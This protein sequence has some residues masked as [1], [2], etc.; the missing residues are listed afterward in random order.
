MW[1]VNATEGKRK[2]YVFSAQKDA[3]EMA[4]SLLS[5]MRSYSEQMVGKQWET[6]K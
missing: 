4:M 3:H 1:N 6:Q 5:E 2:M